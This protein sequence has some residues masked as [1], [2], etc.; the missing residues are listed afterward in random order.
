M[1]PA[2]FQLPRPERSR[3]LFLIFRPLLAIPHMVWAMLYGFVAG[4]IQF[5]SFWAIIFSGRHPKGLWSFLADYFRYSWR[6]QAWSMYLTDEYPPFDGNADRNYPIGVRLEHPSRMSRAT[7]FFRL[8]ILLPHGFYFIGA[9]FVYMIVQFLTWW[10]ILFLGRM[11][12]WQFAQASS[13]FIYTAR[14]NAYML[15]LVDE[16]P[17]FNGVQPRAAEEQFA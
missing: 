9:A 4:I 12:E 14:L 6:L 3:R 13:F 17:P 5:L 8:L 11:A 7:V 15:Y 1:Y 2:I 16:Y 10:T